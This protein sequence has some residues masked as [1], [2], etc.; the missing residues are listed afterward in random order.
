[1]LP[2]GYKPLGGKAATPQWRTTTASRVAMNASDRWRWSTILVSIWPDAWHVTFGVRRGR[3]VGGSGC[4]KRICANS[5]DQ[6][7]GLGNRGPPKSSQERA[8]SALGDWRTLERGSAMSASPL[9]A[10]L[11]SM[12]TDVRRD[13]AHKFS[14]SAWEFTGELW[15]S[16]WGIERWWPRQDS[17]LRPSD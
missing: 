10:D 13:L 1:M 3:A 2:G 14:M 16:T 12:G 6:Y 9:R 11:L 4:P 17:N 15:R 8:M 7:E 5:I